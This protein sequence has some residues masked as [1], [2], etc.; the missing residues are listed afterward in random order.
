MRKAEHI[1]CSCPQ[2]KLGAAS[3]AGKYVHRAINRKIRHETKQRLKRTEP[4]DFMAMTWSTPYT[5]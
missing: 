4:E 5:D 2:C 1:R 3:E